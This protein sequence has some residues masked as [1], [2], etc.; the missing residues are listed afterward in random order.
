M[1]RGEAGVCDTTLGLFVSNS[2]ATAERCAPYWLPLGT[3][4][5]RLFCGSLLSAAI[6]HDGVN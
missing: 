1:L 5:L 3:R 4:R 2:I 6:V